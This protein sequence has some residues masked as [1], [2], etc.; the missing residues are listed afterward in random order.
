MAEARLS[1]PWLQAQPCIRDLARHRAGLV[2][3]DSTFFLG[4][5]ALGFYL[6]GIFVMSEPMTGQADK[7]SYSGVS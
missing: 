7:T 1:E 6:A 2:K 3:L 5:F 4:Q